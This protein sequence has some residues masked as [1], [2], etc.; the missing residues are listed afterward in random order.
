[1]TIKLEKADDGTVNGTMTGVLQFV[2]F[3]KPRPNKFKPGTTQYGAEVESTADDDLKQLKG[4][5]ATKKAFRTNEKTGE[6]Y[7]GPTGKK[8]ISFTSPGEYPDGK[9]APAPLVVDENGKRITVEIGN[10]S[11]GIVQ[12]VIKKGKNSEFVSTRLVAIKI[13][14]LVPYIRTEKRGPVADLLGLTEE[15]L[16]EATKTLDD[17]LDSTLSSPSIL[18]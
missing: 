9:P 13:T 18:S 12:F 2:T 16:E 5:G 4:V 10:G 11:E 6:F 7:L 3:L 15:Q 1:M 14:K 17:D 8:L